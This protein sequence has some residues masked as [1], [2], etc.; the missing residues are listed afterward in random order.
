MSSNDRG[1]AVDA[2]GNLVIRNSASNNTLNYFVIGEQTIG[3]IFTERAVE[4]ATNP[5]TNFQF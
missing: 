4:Q 5:W 3:P 1:I 2:P